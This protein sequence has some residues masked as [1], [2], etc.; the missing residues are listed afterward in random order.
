LTGILSCESLLKR[1][2]MPRIRKRP[3]PKRPVKPTARRGKAERPS[4]EVIEGR[5]PVLEA[6]RGERPINKVLLTRNVGRY[7]TIAEI[8]R[9]AKDAGVVVEWVDARVIERLSVTGISQGVVAMAAPKAYADVEDLLEAAATREERLLVVLLDGI[10]D[11]QNLGAIVRTADAAGVHGVVIP[12]RRA[13]PLTAAVARASAGALEHLAVAR[14]GNLSNAMAQLARN[15][16]RTV[17]V[18]PTGGTDYTQLDYRQATAIVVGAEGKGLSRLVRERC[19]VLVSIPMR[20][21]VASL[22]ASVAA[23]LVMFEAARQRFPSQ[24]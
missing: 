21:K 24:G 18:D 23:A 2:T 3:L 13:A 7:R 11:P 15:N 12:D 9:L 16:V 1:K 4:R 8:L 17:G 10:E 22:N 6:L 20:G 14:V 5:N 19:A